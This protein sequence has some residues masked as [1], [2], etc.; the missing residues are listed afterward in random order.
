MGASPADADLPACGL[1]GRSAV[2]TGTEAFL[3]A[4]AQARKQS[5]RTLQAYRTDLT[6]FARFLHTYVRGTAP[7]L[8]QMDVEAIEAF[9]LEME[10]RRLRHSTVARKLAA[11][12]TFCRFLVSMG[13][14][15]RNP[16]RHLS[17]PSSP[18]EGTRPPGV[19]RVEAALAAVPDS[20]FAGARDR[21][22]LEVLYG[23]G[24]RLG[25]LV[26]LNLT[27][28]DLED[29]TVRVEG[30]HERT[31]PLGSQ[32]VA[33]LQTYLSRRADRLIDRDITQVDAGAVFLSGR[34]RRLHRR[35]V[36]RLVKR[37][38]AQSTSRLGLGGTGGAGHPPTM[39]SSSRA[40][41]R[42]APGPRALRQAFAA[43][44]LEAGADA[45]SV[46]VL[47]GQDFLPATLP[48][49]DVES[50]RESYERAHPRAR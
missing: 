43:H 34:G 50:L 33:A 11:V 17:R 4:A 35:S 18:D 46:G 48:M 27:A 44:L 49:C 21:A 32:A 25:E 30:D 16:A 29:G 15:T 31:V 14:L 19:E 47:L 24:L 41:V 10:A 13:V 1:S 40:A 7:C 37:W 8:A 36:Q 3:A 42:Q 28:L 6:Q 2:E 23:A 9:V 22:I 26:A 45:A 20:R 12:R 5:S 39:P 38:L